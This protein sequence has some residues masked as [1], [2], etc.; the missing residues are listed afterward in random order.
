M[1]PKAD[2]VEDSRGTFSL[3]YK[4]PKSFSPTGHV[5]RIERRKAKIQ[6]KRELMKY[7][8]KV[9]GQ[10]PLIPPSLLQHEIPSVFPLLQSKLFGFFIL[11]VMSHTNCGTEDT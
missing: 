4:P 5:E 6:E 3:F 2:E 8:T 9:V 1:T 10:D 11:R 7:G